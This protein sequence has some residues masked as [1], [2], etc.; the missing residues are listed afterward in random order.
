[1]FVEE[2]KFEIIE[3]LKQKKKATVAELC[4]HFDV[5]RTTIRTDLSDLE[6]HGAIIRTHGGAILKSKTGLDLDI[7]TK[8][9]QHIEA[10]KKIAKLA[11]DLVEE[12]DTIVLDTGSTTQEFAK[13]LGQKRDVTVVTNDLIISLTCEDFE[14]VHIILLGGTVMCRY[15]CTLDDTGGEIMSELSVDKAFMGTTGFTADKGASVPDINHARLKRR[16]TEIANTVILLADSSKF[17][18]NSFA[19]YATPDMF[20]VIVTEEANSY[21]IHET[22]RTDIEV[23]S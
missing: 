3:Y 13:L 17:G 4:D 11:I 9:V 1:M 15:H 19:Q 2:R 8:T 12:G 23:L 5:S 14:S 16:M 6:L 7:R 10:K 22:E 18:K 20:D 21:V